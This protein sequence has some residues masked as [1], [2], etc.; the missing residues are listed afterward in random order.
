MALHFR[1]R[2]T[3]PT[4]NASRERQSQN[5]L[6]NH[7]IEDLSVEFH[8]EGDIGVDPAVGKQMME[9]RIRSPNQILHSDAWLKRIPS[10][11]LK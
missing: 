6:F 8:E 11:L 1:Q 7:T 10:S 5:G 2:C 3:L 4:S 9:I